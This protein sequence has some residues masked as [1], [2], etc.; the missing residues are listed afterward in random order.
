MK[1]KLIA[2]LSLV[3]LIL[4]LCS[5][6]VEGYDYKVDED[7]WVVSF[8]G[9][10][11]DNTYDPSEINDKIARLQ[12]GDTFTVSVKNINKYK[13]STNWYFSNEVLKSL[14][15]SSVASHGAY[16]YTLTYND[17]VIYTSDKIGGDEG[18]SRESGLHEATDSLKDWFYID[19]LKQGESGLMTLKVAFDGDTQVNNYELTEAGILMRYAVELTPKA[20]EE[21]KTFYSKKYEN[22][23]TGDDTQLTLWSILAIGSGMLLIIYVIVSGLKRRGGTEK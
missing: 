9:K 8:D 14:E 11:V 20:Q 4:P 23:K 3:L 1:K 15:D 5:T 2:V 18:T 21:T 10:D 7:K 22:V 6:Q 19:T 17:Q 13:E 12:P 16:N